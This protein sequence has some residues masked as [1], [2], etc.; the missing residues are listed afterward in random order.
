MLRIFNST[1]KTYPNN[2]DVVLAPLRAVLHNEDNGECYIDLQIGLEYLD[3]MTEG[4]IIVADTPEGPQPFRVT[5]PTKTKFRIST[6]AA[7]GT[8]DA[9]NYLIRDTNVVNKA[10][11]AAI[12]Q[13]NNATEPASE[14]TVS[15]DIAKT[16]SYRC[17][18]TSLY[19]AIFELQKRIG[20][21]I[22]RDGFSFSLK[23][24]IQF[25][26][27]ID[28]AYGKNMRDITYTEDWSDVVTKILP[29]GYDGTLL[30]EIYLTSA[31]QYDLPYTKKVD[32]LQDID[33]DDYADDTA[34][35][36]AL[37][38]DLR[39]QAT[40]YLA[41]HCVPQIN[42]TLTANADIKGLG[43]VVRVNDSRLGIN[44]LTNV[45]AYDYDLILNKF[46]SVQFGNFRKTLKGLLS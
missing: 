21:H 35:R 44:L 24:S 6:R 27:E 28:I 41:E 42:Y 3:Y 46:V 20:G 40:A 4:R 8:Y 14:F 19:D 23:N 11:N 43:E 7:H 17:V 10:G 16:T 18:R 33:P 25:D 32:F 31:T 22:V 39:T 26:N 38:A 13:L 30:P 36:A 9:Q 37:V 1:E 29:V 5:N 15:S 45:I 34:Y 12:A 2:G